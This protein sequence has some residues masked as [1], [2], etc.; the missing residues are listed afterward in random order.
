MQ[1]AWSVTF[2]T[3]ACSLLDNQEVSGNLWL[4][5]PKEQMFSES[6]VRLVEQV[7]N[8]CGSV[9]LKIAFMPIPTLFLESH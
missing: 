6:E 1:T 3:L 9:M 5:K 4:F 7:A 8:Q 2:A